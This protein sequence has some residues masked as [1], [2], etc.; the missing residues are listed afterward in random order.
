MEGWDVTG[1][2][3]HGRESSLFIQRG[4]TDQTKSL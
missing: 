2:K 1:G 3:L 4:G